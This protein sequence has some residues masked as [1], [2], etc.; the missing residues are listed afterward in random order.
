MLQEEA[1]SQLPNYA[2][3][4]S[5]DVLVYLAHRVISDPVR[6]QPV[7]CPKKGGVGG[8]GGVIMEYRFYNWHI[9]K[10]AY[11][12]HVAPLKNNMPAMTALRLGGRAKQRLTV[13]T[14]YIQHEYISECKCHMYANLPAN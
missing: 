5:T 7:L 2:A 13:K 12:P 9:Q 10:S 6:K 1:D 14:A 8:R 11:L 4:M 3:M